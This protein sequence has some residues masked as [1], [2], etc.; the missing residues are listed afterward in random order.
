M[1]YVKVHKVGKSEVIAVC[2]ED[3][4]GKCFEEE[5]IY[6]DVNERFYKGDIVDGS[7]ILKICMDA[8]TVNIVGKNSVKLFLDAGIILKENVREVE[9]IPFAMIV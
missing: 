5:K 4:I 6:L 9:G 3:L 8:K 1:I 2:D 7:E